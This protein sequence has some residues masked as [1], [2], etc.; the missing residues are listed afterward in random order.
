MLVKIE[1]SVSFLD[2]LLPICR[3]KLNDLGA[4]KTLIDGSG[5]VKPELGSWQGGRVALLFAEC[6]CR[7]R[8]VNC[9]RHRHFL[10][11]LN[12]ICT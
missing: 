7:A 4:I 12:A 9:K 3:I 2:Y 6:P 8:L 11:N 10:A 5:S 1:R